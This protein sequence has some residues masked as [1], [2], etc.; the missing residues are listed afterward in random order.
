[1]ALSGRLL[2]KWKCFFPP[3]SLEKQMNLAGVITPVRSK[4]FLN[5]VLIGYEI[6]PPRGG[7]YNGFVTFF[8]RLFSV[9]SALLVQCARLMAQKTCSD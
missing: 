6:L 1:V 7:E 2:F 3:L 8:S 9:S 5:S 4:N